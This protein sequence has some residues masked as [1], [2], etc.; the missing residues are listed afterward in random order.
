MN[1]LKIVL[2]ATGVLT[3]MLAPIAMLAVGA[4]YLLSIPFWVAAAGITATCLGFAGLFSQVL[5][6]GLFLVNAAQK[7]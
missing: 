2:K 3:T 4:M 7:G 6:G 1:T 5:I